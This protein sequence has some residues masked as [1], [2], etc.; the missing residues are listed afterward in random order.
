VAIG[1]RIP[2]VRR[3]VEEA[4]GQVASQDPWLSEHPPSVEWIG[5]TWEPTETPR[6]HPLVRAL[7]AAVAGVTARPASV[8]GAT[9][10]SDLR[11][12]SNQFGV[13][14]AHFGPGDIRQAH[15]TDEYI[16]LSEVE[17]AALALA[18]TIVQFCGSS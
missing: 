8:R 1:E 14:G 5:G 11:L 4:V 7:C 3:Q 13:P 18:V 10:G 9:Y 16:T 15:F 12:F 17:T 6:D 2:D